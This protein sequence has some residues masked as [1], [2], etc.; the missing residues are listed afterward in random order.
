MAAPTDAGFSAVDIAA[1]RRA[2][3]AERGERLVDVP[4]DV[5]DVLEA[6]RDPHHVLRHAGRELLRL[7]ELAM[8]RRR[9]MDDERSRVADVGEV[10]HQLRRLDEADAGG[11]A[12]LDAEREQAGR[13]RDA[14]DLAHLFGATSA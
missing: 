2:Y 13:A 4:E 3:A 14:A 6:D 10:A 8:R 7:V 1:S 12:A 11:E 5:V 9:R